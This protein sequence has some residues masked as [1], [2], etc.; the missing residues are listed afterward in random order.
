ME[1]VQGKGIVYVSYG[2][3]IQRDSSAEGL[4]Y[5][6]KLF[7]PLELLRFANIN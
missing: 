5:D 1:M 7:S 4:G 2:F 3:V 6:V